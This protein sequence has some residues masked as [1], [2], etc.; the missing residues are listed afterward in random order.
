LVTSNSD[1]TL[2]WEDHATNIQ[3]D[4][5][6]ESPAASSLPPEKPETLPETTRLVGD[7]NRVSELAIVVIFDNGIGRG[8]KITIDR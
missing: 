2:T 7:F 4:Y 3:N 8:P 1:N 6:K 5:S